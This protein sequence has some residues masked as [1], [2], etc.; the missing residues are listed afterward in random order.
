[1]T[2]V[3][4]QSARGRDHVADRYLIRMAARAPSVHNTQPW[5]FTAGQG[6][7]ALHAD[8]ERGL[9]AEDPA[10]RELVISCGAA[11]A[12]LRLAMRQL[13]FAAD[14]A[15]LPDAG[16]PGLLARVRWGRHVTPTPYEDELY[17]AIALRH[18]RRGPFAGDLPP[19]VLQELS[20]AVRAE[21]AD[22][23][24]VYGAV[25]GRE[26]ADLVREAEL[27]QR[28]SPR[29]VSERARW[30]RLAGDGRPDGVV[31]PPRPPG[32]WNGPEFVGRDFAG[33]GDQDPW[34][35]WAP[36]DPSLPGV[37]ALITT[38]DDREPGWL[39]AGQ[40]LQRLL[41]HATARGAG[42]AIHTQPL[43][44]PLI[45]ARIRA[46]FTGRDYPQVLLRLG[47]GGFCAPSAR[48]AVGDVLRVRAA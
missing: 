6:T 5:Y 39:A 37:I 22:L 25:C 28:A 13:G 40:A 12:N 46:E 11:L 31:P 38:R 3:P 18:T 34:A 42:A 7:L 47:R 16:L 44:V 30:T 1:M 4:G 43:E 41:L 20:R 15:P 45:R 14:V 23:Y 17:R 21:R 2:A 19:L 33:H 26:L 9:P 24:V 48:R 36:D 29:A 32:R 8:A 35:P 10:G 27:A